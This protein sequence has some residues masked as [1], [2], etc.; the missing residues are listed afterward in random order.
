MAK[1]IKKYYVDKDGKKRLSTWQAEFY[2]AQRYPR[3]K[4]V[5]LHTKDEEDAM[6]MM[7][8]REREYILGAFDPWTNKVQKEGVLLSEAVATFL[9]N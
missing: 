2:D 6:R 5:S 4:R 9:K 7:V 8:R 1:L 3:R